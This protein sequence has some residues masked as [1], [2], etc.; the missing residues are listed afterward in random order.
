MLGGP[1]LTGSHATFGR[2]MRPQAMSYCGLLVVPNIWC[3][4]KRFH[5]A[6]TFDTNLGEKVWIQLIATF[7]PLAVLIF[8]SFPNT[9]GSLG[10]ESWSY[11]Y[12]ADNVSKD[13]KV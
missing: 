2:C 13:D 4:K 12:R 6:N 11:M 8:S 3:S 7:C 9:G 5:P 10:V 1:K